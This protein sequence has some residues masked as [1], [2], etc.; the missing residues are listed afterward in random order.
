MP[1][2]IQYD[3]LSLEVKLQSTALGATFFLPELVGNLPNLFF[4]FHTFSP[5]VKE[6]NQTQSAEPLWFSP[7]AE[8]PHRFLGLPF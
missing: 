3:R 5:L 7:E 6:L 2:L 8:Y 4:P 1:L